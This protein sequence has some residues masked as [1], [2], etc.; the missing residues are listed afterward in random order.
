MIKVSDAAGSKV[1]VTFVVDCEQCDE[2]LS[3]VGDFNDW[4][5]HK[6]PLKKRSNGTRSAAIELE[7]GAS[8]RFK[9]L[10]EGGNWFCDSTTECIGEGGAADSMLNL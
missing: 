5:P 8:Y 6:T 1:K 9:Y 10:G 7:S 4:D 3:V 2:P